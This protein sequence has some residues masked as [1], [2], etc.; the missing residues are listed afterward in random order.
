MKK[1]AL[2]FTLI[3]F[4][5][6]HNQSKAKGKLSKQVQGKLQ[7]KQK[8]EPKQKPEAKQKK[9][10]QDKTTAGCQATCTFNTQWGADLLLT[11]TM[12]TVHRSRNI[13][14]DSCYTHCFNSH[15]FHLA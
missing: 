10:N 6:K 9:A 14:F 15:Q 2:S 8:P 4:L 3:F 1:A 13:H 12:R 11:T 5:S 7:A